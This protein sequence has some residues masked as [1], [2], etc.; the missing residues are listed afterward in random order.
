MSLK[1]Q[2]H[3]GKLGRPHGGGDFCRDESVMSSQGKGKD[4]KMRKGKAQRWIWTMQK[5]KSVGSS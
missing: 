5:I 3:R 1:A 4:G 2:S